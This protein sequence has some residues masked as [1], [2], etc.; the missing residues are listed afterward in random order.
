MRSSGTRRNRSRR[1]EISVAMMLVAS[2]VYLGISNFLRASDIAESSADAGRYCYI[3]L[4]ARLAFFTPE[5]LLIFKQRR[6]LGCG[7][8]GFKYRQNTS[9]E[10]CGNDKIFTILMT[11]ASLL[12]MLFLVSSV[13]ILLDSTPKSR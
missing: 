3:Q 9:S 10:G 6:M 8:G 11:G 2:G 13:G 12:D 5:M 1:I 4:L 7:K